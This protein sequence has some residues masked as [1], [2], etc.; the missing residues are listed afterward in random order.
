MHSAQKKRKVLE[1]ETQTLLGKDS[2]V[3]WIGILQPYLCSPQ[4]HPVLTS[5]SFAVTYSKDKV[6]NWDQQLCV[7]NNLE[8]QLDICG[9]TRCL[10]SDSV[11]SKKKVGRN[12]ALSG[13]I[14]A[15]YGTMLWVVD[16]TPSPHESDGSSFSGFTFKGNSSPPLL[17]QM[18]ASEKEAW[19]SRETRL[20]LCKRLNVTI[21]WEKYLLSKAFCLIWSLV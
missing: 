21:S 18:A 2:S 15:S 3:S 7:I 12:S 10:V 8:G 5:E 16:K 11:S 1:G 13:W 6:L 14:S 9:S 4:H 20:Q 19:R 17:R